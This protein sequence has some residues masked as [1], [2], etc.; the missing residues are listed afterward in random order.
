MSIGG[1]VDDTLF[2]LIFGKDILFS[3]K[4]RM[5]LTENAASFFI[6]YVSSCKQK[7]DTH[8]R[9]DFRF[10]D[11]IK[12][13]TVFVFIWHFSYS[14]VIVLKTCAKIKMAYLR[15]SGFF[16]VFVHIFVCYL[17]EVTVVLCRFIKLLH[18]SVDK[19]EIN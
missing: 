9:C 18:E 11:R 7:N 15:Y 3:K 6:L 12:K 8:A 10:F 4:F 17:F 5:K 16:P 14:K 13:W 1:G 2:K 19:I